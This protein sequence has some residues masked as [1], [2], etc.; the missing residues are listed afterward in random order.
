MAEDIVKLL[1]LTHQFLWVPFYLFVR[2][3]VTELPTHAEEESVGLCLSHPRLPSQDSG[4]PELPNF[5]SPPVFLPTPFN[6][7]RPN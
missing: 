5:G 2:T 6:A 1:S 7:E 4:I 3:I